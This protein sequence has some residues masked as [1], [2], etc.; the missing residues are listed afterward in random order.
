MPTNNVCQVF[1][2]IRND[3]IL[4]LDLKK[5]VDKK[6]HEVKTLESRK[7]QLEQALRDKG[8]K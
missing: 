7:A 5:T 6:E 4:L 1:E 8:K 3:I 2:D